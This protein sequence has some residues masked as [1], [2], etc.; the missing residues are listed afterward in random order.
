MLGGDAGPAGGHVPPSWRNFSKRFLA[1]L[2]DTFHLLQQ[3][4]DASSPTV[5]DLPPALHHRFIGET[6]SF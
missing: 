3:Q 6:A 5:D 1:D 2:H 4:D